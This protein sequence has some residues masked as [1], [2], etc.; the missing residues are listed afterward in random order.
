MPDINSN[1]EDRL[2]K[3]VKNHLKKTSGQ[4]ENEVIK[5]RIV[6]NVLKIQNKEKDT[7][8][9]DLEEQIDMYVIEEAGASY[10]VRKELNVRKHPYLTL[11]K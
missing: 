5:L 2:F 4:L 7:K 8:I 3:R 10:W 11:A 6:N 1:F 9:M